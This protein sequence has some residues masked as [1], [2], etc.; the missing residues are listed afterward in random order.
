MKCNGECRRTADC[1][2]YLHDEHEER[3]YRAPTPEEVAAELAVSKKRCTR[4][5]EPDENHVSKRA[6][7]QE[8]DIP[9]MVIDVT[10]RP[11][12]QAKTMT[13]Q[14]L[15]LLA[16]QRCANQKGTEDSGDRNWFYG[17]TAMGWWDSKADAATNWI[18]ESTWKEEGQWAPQEDWQLAPPEDWQP[19][20]QVHYYCLDPYEE[21]LWVQQYEQE[22]LRIREQAVQAREEA[23]QQMEAEVQHT[24]ANWIAEQNAAAEKWFEEKLG[25]VSAKAADKEEREEKERK[26]R[27][28]AGDPIATSPPPPPSSARQAALRASAKAK[29]RG[30][31]GA[32]EPEAA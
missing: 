7:M 14:I 5:V 4:E 25:W 3:I 10:G 31:G 19:G 24:A 21:R 29:L 13:E 17:S 15:E 18:A 30:Q 6:R 32:N 27:F 1:C 2:D 8:T 9:E 16:K 20:Q 23:V 11:L 12:E 22:Q 26:E 28:W